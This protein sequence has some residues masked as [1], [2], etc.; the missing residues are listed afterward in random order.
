MLRFSVSASAADEEHQ[1]ANTTVL[2][3]VCYF[4]YCQDLFNPKYL[5]ICLSAN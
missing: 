2:T 4:I 1:R 3:C 5:N